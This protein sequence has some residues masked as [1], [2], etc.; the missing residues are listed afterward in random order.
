MQN[1]KDLYK[2]L[3]EKLSILD[4][5]RWM[6]LWH[7]QV[8]FLETE[9]RF[10]APAVFFSFRALGTTDLSKK[11]QRVPLQVDIYLFFETFADSYHQSFNQDSALGFLDLLTQV[12]ATLHGSGGN[13]Y[14]EMR[15]VSFSPVDT[16]GSGNTY[17]MSFTC[18]LVDYSAQDQ[19]VD[20][21]ID[22]VQL[23]PGAAPGAIDDE[24]LFDV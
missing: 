1:W 12:H 10:P 2:E 3:C 19:E 17:L 11:V 6:D 18:Q 21:D 16:G 14:S 22:D 7:N 23:V 15:R 24:P 20:V 4:G 5:I 13:N 9:H 8:N